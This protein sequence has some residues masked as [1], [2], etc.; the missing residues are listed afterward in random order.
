[1]A[2][3]GRECFVYVG[4]YTEKLPH[5][6]GKAEGIY[7]YRLERAS[8]ELHYV[9]TTTGVE[10]PSFVTV[11]PSGKY[12]YAVEEVGGTPERP[13]GAVRAFR[14]DA[15]THD[16]HP[17][18]GQ[19][20]GGAFP[21]YVAVDANE[22]W[23]LVANHGGGSVAVFP[24][25]PDG[26]LGPATSI[27]QHEPIDDAKSHPHSIIADPTN[28]FVLVPDAGLDRVMVYRLSEQGVLEPNDPPFAVLAPKTGP[29]HIDFGADG[30]YAY[31]IGESASTMTT[32]RYDGANGVLTPVQTV[33][34]LP[35]DYDGHSACADV[36]V[37]P[38]GR[39]V[40]GSNR[41]DDSIASF[42]VDAATGEL[43]LVGHTPTGGQVPR[44]FALDATGAVLL[45]ANQ[46][47]DTVVA[48]AIDATTGALHPT[49]LVSSIPTPV[50]LC[51][52]EV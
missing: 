12:L 19:S 36:H 3:A 13:H 11:A 44:G 39:F 7:V 30:T 1:M 35:P 42:G 40:Y 10:N 5:V 48:F 22:R 21:C 26:A 9:S 37:H 32:L 43:T 27:V 20:T 23:V 17:I 15:E 24:I 8:G 4:T 45:A 50:C 49:E 16:L 31:V 52:V 34:T 47:T 2:T 41:G 29:R 28:R 38:S 18:N 33:S 51:I 6:D 14:I 25:G 46:N